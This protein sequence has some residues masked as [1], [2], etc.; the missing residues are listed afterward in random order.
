MMNFL[1][2][3]KE[4]DITELNERLSQAEQKV[5]KIKGTIERHKKQAEKK[6][7]IIRENGCNEN[8]KFAY[9]QTEMY[10]TICDYE[11]KMDDIKTAGQKLRDAEIIVNNWK[12]KIGKEK[13]KNDVERIPVIEEFL[14]VWKIKSI[15][16][17]KQAYIKYIE[18][19]KELNMKQK[20]L[21]K[22]KE[23]NN[24]NYC[25]FGSKEDREKILNKEKELGIDE[26]TI[27][28]SMNRKF[29]VL[30]TKM[31]NDY[32]S[33]PNKREKFLNNEIEK[34]KKN[35]RALFINRVKEIT[36]TIQDAKGLR[37]G[38]NGEI[39]GIVI[40]EKGKAKV[41]TIS[42]GGYNI[43]CWHFRVLVKEVI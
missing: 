3:R 32:K 5:E 24:L 39:N 23:E 40:G 42:A 38:G 8:D 22:W 9:R 26:Q 12:S 36:G 4:L 2:K 15:E 16:W 41:E 31:Y 10:W 1:L 19:L 28:F 29:N 17:H 35:K 13:A 7:Q 18:Y 33:N 14:K 25:Y 11:S 34:E 21:K 27:A 43:Q 30:I 37:I 20:E 6:L